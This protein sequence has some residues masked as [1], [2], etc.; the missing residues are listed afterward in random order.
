MLKLESKIGTI[1]QNDENIYNFL[2]DFNNLKHLIP[3]D[4]VKDFE[5]TQDTCHFSVPPAG[6]VGLH[7]VN[8]EPYKTIKI[9]GEGMKNDFFFW[10]Q[11]KQVAPYDTKVRLTIHA[12]VNPMIKALVSKPLQKFIDTL[13]VQ[14]G[15]LQFA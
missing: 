13:A 2:S 4:K 8:L 6:K 12:E 3:S 10:I 5:A 9:A 7:I 14:L 15:N 1:R 11:L